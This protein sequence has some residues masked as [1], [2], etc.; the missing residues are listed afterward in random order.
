MDTSR[1]YWRDVLTTSGFS[2]IP[3]WTVN[4]VPGFGEHETT[5]SNEVVATLRL[6]ADDLAVPLS[7]VLLSA[8]AKV[9]AALTGEQDV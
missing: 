7:S 6:L 8:H 5:I 3:R 4:S 2:A 9:L 1:D